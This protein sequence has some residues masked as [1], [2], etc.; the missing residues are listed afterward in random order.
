M[1]IRYLMDQS[2]VKLPEN[3]RQRDAVKIKKGEA[4]MIDKIGIHKEIETEIHTN[5]SL[6]STE[7][8][9]PFKTE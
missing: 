2:I 8:N 6:N 9:T 3:G 5:L 4:I 7:N 1:I